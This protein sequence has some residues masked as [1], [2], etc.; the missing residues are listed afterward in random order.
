MIPLRDKLMNSGFHRCI[1]RGQ[2]FISAGHTL[3]HDVTYA[4][5]TLRFFHPTPINSVDESA[6]G[7]KSSRWNAGF[8]A[9]YDT[10]IGVM[11]FRPRSNV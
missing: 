9:I 6:T 7:T 1:R 8:D 4:G 5:N 3:V 2:F 10:G 11:Q